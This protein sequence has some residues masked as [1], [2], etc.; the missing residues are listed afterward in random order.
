MS[1]IDL[2][3]QFIVEN[4]EKS[5]KNIDF[6]DIKDKKI[7]L[8]NESYDTIIVDPPRKGLDGNAI[9]FIKKIKPKSIIYVSCNP[10]TLARDLKILCI[11]DKLYKPLKIKNVDMFPHTMHIETVVL[12]TEV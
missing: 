4:K 5:F 9:M 1:R 11:D 6:F 2:K 7:V 8:K 3:E 10:A 12:L